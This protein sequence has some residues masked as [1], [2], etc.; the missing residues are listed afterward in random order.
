VLFESSQRKEQNYTIRL[1]L[2]LLEYGKKKKGMNPSQEDN[3]GSG[4]STAGEEA[5]MTM[6]TTTEQQP[7]LEE[8][9]KHDVGWRRIVRH[10]TPSYVYKPNT[11]FLTMTGY[12]HG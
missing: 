6:T 7:E 3:V 11:L 8:L 2:T 1:P 4:S 10:F 5:P 9:T 12:I